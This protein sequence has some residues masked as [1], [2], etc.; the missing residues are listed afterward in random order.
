MFFVVGQV[1]T[2][3]NT[4]ILHQGCSDAVS[5]VLFCKVT[6]TCH[7]Y[8]RVP[9][10]P[11]CLSKRLAPRSECVPPLPRRGGGVAISRFRVEHRR[12]VRALLAKASK[13]VPTDSRPRFHQLWSTLWVARCFGCFPALVSSHI[14][15]GLGISFRGGRVL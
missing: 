11:G 8:H 5:G 15:S 10:K 12:V 4:W 3:P 13:V 14:S 6:I 9:N 7:A 2:F 1:T